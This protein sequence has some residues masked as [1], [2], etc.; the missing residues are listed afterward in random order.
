[1]QGKNIVIELRGKN[2]L[3]I[4]TRKHVK[5]KKKRG[6]GEGTRG[7]VNLN[8]YVRIEKRERPCF[9]LVLVMRI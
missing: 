5:R 7:G 4:M 8:E 3:L 9:G 1:L 2:A 6:V